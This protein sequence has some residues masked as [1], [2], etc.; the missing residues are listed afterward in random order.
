MLYLGTKK[1]Q[2]LSPK[3]NKQTNKQKTTTTSKPNLLCFTVTFSF[4]YE[5]KKKTAGNLSES[6]V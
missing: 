6:Y 5:K 3:R 2:L 4:T 1:N